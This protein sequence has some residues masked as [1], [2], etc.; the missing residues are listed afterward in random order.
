M[1]ILLVFFLSVVSGF[2]QLVIIAEVDIVY[3]YHFCMTREVQVI[4]H[5]KIRYQFQ[6]VRFIRVENILN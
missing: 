3:L 4:A 6:I 2:V 5:A 1:N